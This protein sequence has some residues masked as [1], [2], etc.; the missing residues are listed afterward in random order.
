MRLNYRERLRSLGLLRNLFSLIVLLIATGLVYSQGTVII[1]DITIRGNEAISVDAIRAAMRSQPGQPVTANLLLAD[2]DAIR[3]LGFF[4]DVRVLSRN[5]S[6]TEAEVIVE[7]E[8][9]PVVRE[10][11]VDGNTVISTQRLYEIIT[12]IQPLGLVYNNRNARQ[13]RDAVARAYDEEGF[14]IEIDQLG[15]DPDS[16]NTLL[17]SLIEPT[18][19]EIRIEGLTRTRQSVI[20]RIIKTRPGQPYSV[21]QWRRDVE[22]V[23]YTYWFEDIRTR[24]EPT[25]IPGRYNLILEVVE[26]RTGQISAGVA[27]DPQSRI[28][29]TLTY[30]DTN[31]MGLGQSLGVQLSQST[32]GSGPSAEIAYSNRYFDN[33]GTW[34]SGSIYSKVVYN[35]S[36]TGIGPFDGP[37]GGSSRF[38]ERRTGGEFTFGRTFNDIYNASLGL[39]FENIETLSLSSDPAVEFIQ[40]DGELA[41]F[42][43]GLD[44]DTRFPRNDPYEGSLTSLLIEPG[45]S[46]IRRIGGNVGDFDDILG[47]NTFVRG[48]V[49]YRSYWKMRQIPDDAPFDAVV[50]VIAFR[51]RYAHIEGTVPFFEQLFVGGT[52]SLRGYPNQRFWGDRAVLATIEYRHPIQSS[53]TVI[54]FADYGGAWG[55]Y[56]S[57]NEFQQSSRPDLRLGYG[58]GVSFRSPIGPIRLDFAFNQDGG[59]RTHFSF[60]TSF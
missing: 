50:P 44:R 51:A 21:R 52:G 40:Q 19:N 15:P 3:D 8:E 4:L 10:V 7:V 33:K 38:D 35:F 24:E 26:A 11:R 30:N 31:F 47:N 57:I 29:G 58:I 12:E 53:I 37:L 18:V 20:E 5:I 9:N 2:E 60:G 6:E 48:T 22:E 55:G 39:R 25:E 59:S 36:G 34:V 1:R 49:E 56:G 54:G 13:I 45:F 32:V 41:V 23:Y 27:L 28:V 42:Q 46:N 16:R 14:F 43:L 17:V